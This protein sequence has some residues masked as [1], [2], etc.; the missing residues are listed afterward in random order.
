MKRIALA[1]LLTFALAAGAAQAQGTDATGIP[2]QAPGA[3]G[4]VVG[5][6]AATM[7]GGGE[8]RVIAYSTGGAGGRASLEQF[9]RLTS[10]AGTDGDG[11]RWDD[12]APAFGGA[13]REAWLIGGGENARLVYASPATA[14]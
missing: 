10:F 8:D 14:R 5:G 1:S 11:P 4:N 3:T 12:A 2:G 6:R 9:G 13:G 7:A